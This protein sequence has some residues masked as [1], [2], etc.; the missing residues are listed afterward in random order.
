METKLR[1]VVAG[2]DGRMGREL[3]RVAAEDADIAVV[4][5]L[6]FPGGPGA[7][8]PYAGSERAFAHLPVSPTGADLP[9]FD[10]LVDFTHPGAVAA[11]GA[12]VAARNAAWVLGTTGLDESC[13]AVVDET[14]RSCAVVASG[15]FSV[16]IGALLELCAGVAA[17]LGLDADCEIIETHHSRKKDAPSGTARML[18][19]AIAKVRGQQLGEVARHG[20]QGFIGERPRP[21]IGFHAIRGGDVVGEH[22]VLF[23]WPGERIELTHRAS[24]RGIFARGALRAARWTLGRGPGRYGLSDVLGP[25]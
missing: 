15:N 1:V 10:A 13:N 18:G 6:G 25:E 11:H 3:L 21:E 19:E 17:M 5:L 20:R 8:L 22:T 4:G 24:D 23:A 16:G 14:A 2:P 12:L 9:P 7:G